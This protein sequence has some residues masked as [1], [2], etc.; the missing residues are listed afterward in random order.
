MSYDDI[1][2]KVGLAATTFRKYL[3]IFRSNGIKA[4]LEAWSV[5]AS[6]SPWIR[7]R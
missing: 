1:I 2:Y 7:G 6:L 4:S 5:K 3:Y